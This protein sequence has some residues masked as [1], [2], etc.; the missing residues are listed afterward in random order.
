MH[1]QTVRCHVV[2]RTDAQSFHS[3]TGSAARKL[4]TKAPRITGT[5]SSRHGHDFISLALAKPHLHDLSLHR[6]QEIEPLMIRILLSIR[7]QVRSLSCH[8][9]PPG[10]LQLD[11]CCD[12]KKAAGSR[13]R[14]ANRFL[15]R[16]VPQRCR[17]P[18]H[19]CCILR[20]HR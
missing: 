9:F 8:V 12:G 13:P 20:Q 10:N 1:M 5:S 14:P 3:S 11:A 2:S 16:L 7:T 17:V 18:S 19:T 6:P 4:S 15:P